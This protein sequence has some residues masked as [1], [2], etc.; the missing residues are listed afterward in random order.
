MNFVTGNLATVI[1]SQQN[2]V[3][4]EEA[5]NAGNAPL[6]HVEQ[7]KF[8]PHTDEDAQGVDHEPDNT[9]TKEGQASDAREEE[10]EQDEEAQQHPDQQEP[11]V[12]HVVQREAHI[13]HQHLHSRHVLL[14][15]QRESRGHQ[16]LW[17]QLRLELCFSDPR[18]TPVGWQGIDNDVPVIEA[19]GGGG[20]GGQAL[21]EGHG[22]RLKPVAGRRN[23][24][25]GRL[26][27]GRHAWLEPRWRRRT[28]GHGGHREA[29]ARWGTRGCQGTQVW[30]RGTGGRHFFERSIHLERQWGL[31][32]LC[33]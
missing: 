26:R 2:L 5:I 11:L 33:L 9:T 17:H 19:S 3:P 12:A 10:A 14:H 30:P 16:F 18:T 4:E 22:H 29:G 25:V 28:H 31:N 1:E 24:V 7:L 32:C 13:V 8:E 20:P 21:A 6:E 27:L 15:R 23:R